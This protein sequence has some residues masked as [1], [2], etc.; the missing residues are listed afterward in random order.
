MAL[1]THPAEG[2]HISRLPGLQHHHEA[3]IHC[4]HIALDF[5][6]SMTNLQKI[7]AAKVETAKAR[8]QKP[9]NLLK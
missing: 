2:A 4:T 6:A 8:K 9:N 5:L 3:A 7:E 1:P